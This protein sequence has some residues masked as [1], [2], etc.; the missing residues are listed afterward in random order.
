MDLGRTESRPIAGTRSHSGVGAENGKMAGRLRH[1]RS[2]REGV[3]VVTYLN[4]CSTE[5][6]PR[7]AVPRHCGAA[8]QKQCPPRNSLAVLALRQRASG[9][10]VVGVPASA[11][12][13][14]SNRVPARRLKAELQ[15]E[16]PHSRPEGPV[17]IPGH[18]QL[19]TRF[20]PRTASRRCDSIVRRP[21]RRRRESDGF[22]GR[23]R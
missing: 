20:V 12:L 7:P 10:R 13:W 4:V 3:F 17:G 15:Q 14:R 9:N 22:R 18:P 1:R 16:P 2:P 19:L 6:Q 5:V 21:A 11:G 8:S 23:P